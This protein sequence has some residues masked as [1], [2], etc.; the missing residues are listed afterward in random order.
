MAWKMFE[1]YCTIQFGPSLQNNSLGELVK[2]KQIDSV[3]EYQ[4]QF[5]RLLARA[6]MVRCHQQV[7]VFTI[8]LINFLHLEAEMQS[9]TILVHIMSITTVFER[10]QQLRALTKGN[11][12]DPS[13]SV[14]KP[15]NSV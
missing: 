3:E 9:P 11:Y 4:I 12:S 10:K 14:T 1:E 7:N 13:Q 5:Q 6:S 2:L 8:G 15:N